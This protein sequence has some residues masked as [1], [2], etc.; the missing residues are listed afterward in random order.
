[1]IHSLSLSFSLSCHCCR[2]SS[3]LLIRSMPL[4]QHCD[5][6]S[7]RSFTAKITT[8]TPFDLY[9][10]R[11]N[12]WWHPQ[13]IHRY[14]AFESLPNYIVSIVENLISKDA[15]EQQFLSVCFLRW[16]NGTRMNA[17]GKRQEKKRKRD[18]N[19]KEEEEQQCCCL[20]CCCCCYRPLTA[21]CCRRKDTNF[22]WNGWD[23]ELDGNFT[24]S[25]PDTRTSWYNMQPSMFFALGIHSTNIF[26]AAKYYISIVRLEEFVL[27]LYVNETTFASG[28][29]IDLNKKTSTFENCKRK[30]NE[31]C[32]HNYSPKI[33]RCLVANALN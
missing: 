24:I 23:N 1:M 20:R 17:T 16:Q 27:Y 25:K 4:T 32:C 31:T 10:E 5:V 18:V 11:H 3:L 12:V 21:C 6:F 7:N 14:Y 2:F 26:S 29:K 13:H 22:W 9:W 30:T 33:Y 19:I 8:I 28:C 15:T